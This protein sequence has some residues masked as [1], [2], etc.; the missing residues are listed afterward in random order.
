MRACT[1]EY[2]FSIEL[3]GAT[4]RQGIFHDKKYDLGWSASGLFDD[5]AD[6]QVL[7]HVQR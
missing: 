3:V 6:E 1:D 2:S 5:V 7:K 4:N